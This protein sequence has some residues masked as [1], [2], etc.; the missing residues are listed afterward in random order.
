MIDLGFLKRLIETVESSDIDTLEISRWGTRIRI[1]KSAPN[2]AGNAASQIPVQEIR[3]GTA[4]TNPETAG[5][6]GETSRRP[7]S[8]RS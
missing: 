3:L 2:M 8:R 6:T 4:A 5:G 1:S 7:C